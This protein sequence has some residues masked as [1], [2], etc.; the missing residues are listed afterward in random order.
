MSMSTNKIVILK[1]DI[2][3][4]RFIPCTLATTQF[5]TFF[6]KEE[7]GAQTLFALGGVEFL[8]RLKA[9]ISQDCQLVVNDI[10]EQVFI[11]T[12]HTHP[13]TAELTYNSADVRKATSTSATTKKQRGAGKTVQGK[14]KMNMKSWLATLC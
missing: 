9:D 13:E 4:F 8:Q 14:P 2:Y 5:L 12:Q 1:C 3:S 11:K 6:F 7:I 10:L